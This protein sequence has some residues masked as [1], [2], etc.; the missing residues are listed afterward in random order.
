MSRFEC[1]ANRATSFGARLLMDGQELSGVRAVQMN[2]AAGE[3]F[4]TVQVEFDAA[5][6]EVDCEGK[7]VPLV[8]LPELED[9]VAWALYQKLRTRFECRTEKDPPPLTLDNC[10]A[11][12]SFQEPDGRGSAAV[13]R[14]AP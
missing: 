6:L 1:K 4:N 8:H 5:A 13:R 11:S 10:A 3:G 7:I 12:G 14:L 2:L 9:R